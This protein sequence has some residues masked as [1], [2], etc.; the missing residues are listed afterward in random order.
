MFRY[1][2]SFYGGEFSTPRPTPKLEDN[3]MSAVSDCLLNTF[4]GDDRDSL[5]TD[6]QIQPHL[7]YKT[8]LGIS[9]MFRHNRSIT[10]AVYKSISY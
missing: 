1:K 2:T 4:A 8:S 5:I 9:Y 6:R 10:Q 3:T 7:L